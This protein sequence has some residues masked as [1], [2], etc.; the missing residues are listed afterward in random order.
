MLEVSG[1]ATY[2]SFRS[3]VS[4]FSEVMGT[5]PVGELT[6]E[7]TTPGRGQL[8]ALFV[9]AGNIVN[10][11]PGASE[12]AAALD[13]LEL[14]VSFDFY[15]T[16]TNTHAH[17]ILPD[18]TALERSD[19]PLFP[20]LHSTAPYMQWT[21]QVVDPR[22]DVRP[23]WWVLDQICRRT[24]IAPQPTPA[25]RA[26]WRLGIRPS[27]PTLVDLFLRIGP[28]GDMFGLRRRGSRL[29]RKKLLANPRG[30]LLEEFVPTGGLRRRL[31]HRDGRV[32]LDVPEILA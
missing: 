9:G 30:F 24:G 10:T 5:V 29:S 7:I 27:L 22:E 17:Y 26:L 21:E 15:R 32:R 25:T 12:L 31:P 8:R 11:S 19:F 20:I 6:R 28:Y 13:D 3:R 18:L 4:G 14:F 2:G 1:L 23:A 16:E